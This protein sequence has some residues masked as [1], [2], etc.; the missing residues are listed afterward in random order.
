MIS[1]TFPTPRP[2]VRWDDRCAPP[3]PAVHAVS[4][5][6]VVHAA[7]DPGGTAVKHHW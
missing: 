3:N 7:V 1:A 5:T 4:R 2:E 6:A